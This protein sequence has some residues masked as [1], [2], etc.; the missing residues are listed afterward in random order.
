MGI[1]NKNK[2][3]SGCSKIAE[4]TTPITAPLAPTAV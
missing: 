4:Y 3:I 2:L 1:K